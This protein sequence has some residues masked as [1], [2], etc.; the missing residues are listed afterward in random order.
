MFG[1][2]LSCCENYRLSEEQKHR[3]SERHRSRTKALITE[4]RQKVIEDFY[5]KVRGTWNRLKNDQMKLGEEVTD[6]TGYN[7]KL[8]DIEDACNKYLCGEWD[9]DELLDTLEKLE[10]LRWLCEEV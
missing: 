10:S 8:C 3:S 7:K 1:Y 4:R 5:W 2:C 6:D 9:Y